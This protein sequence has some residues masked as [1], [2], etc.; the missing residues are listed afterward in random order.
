MDTKE[1]TNEKKAVLFQ[2]FL[3]H[4]TRQEPETFKKHSTKKNHLTPP[5]IYPSSSVV[6]FVCKQLSYCK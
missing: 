6:L 2:R 3:V 4:R 1:S 5:F